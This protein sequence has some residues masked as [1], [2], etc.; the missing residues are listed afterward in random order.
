MHRIGKLPF[1]PARVREAGL[2]LGPRHNSQRVAFSVLVKCWTR[3]RDQ[4]RL[5]DRWAS[6]TGGKDEVQGAVQLLVRSQKR[7]RKGREA[8]DI[9][10]EGATAGNGDQRSR[11]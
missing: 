2:S 3:S 7:L 8:V 4:C 5:A 9:D 10:E 6:Q 1:P 11:A